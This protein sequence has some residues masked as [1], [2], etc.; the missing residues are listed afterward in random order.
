MASPDTQTGP[1]LRTTPA[2]QGRLGRPVF[3]V[4]LIST[5]LAALALF[6]AWAWRAP[7][8]AD[9]ER[10]NGKVIAPTHAF[11]APEPA[12]VTQQR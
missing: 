4:L 12:P 10:N 5:I 7:E 8:M 1:V 11:D 2:R 9:A 6:A 3:W